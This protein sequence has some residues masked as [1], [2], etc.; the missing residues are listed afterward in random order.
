MQPVLAKR[1]FFC[2]VGFLK[3]CEKTPQHPPISPTIPLLIGNLAGWVLGWVLEKHPPI[4]FSLSIA[5]LRDL[6]GSWGVFRKNSFREKIPPQ[7]GGRIGIS[8]HHLLAAFYEHAML[9]FRREA[10]ALEVV[11]NRNRCFAFESWN[12]NGREKLIP[13]SYDF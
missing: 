3:F 6:G 12:A 10:A 7:N 5:V 13:N 11:E 2:F 4:N 1:V 8:P 9:R